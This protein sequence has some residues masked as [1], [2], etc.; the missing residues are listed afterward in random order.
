MDF[1]DIDYLSLYKTLSY[2]YVIINVNKISSVCV[3]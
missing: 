3:P 1:K 2:N